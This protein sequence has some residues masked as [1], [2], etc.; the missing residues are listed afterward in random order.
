[1]LGRAR[2]YARVL[3]PAY[4]HLR[5]A[6]PISY[7]YYML[8][9]AI[10]VSREI[11]ALRT[12]AAGLA[13]CP[14]GASAVA[15]TDLPI[16]PARTAAL[17]GFSSTTRHAM[18]AVASRDVPLRLLGGAVGLAVVL[19]R[20]AADLQLWSTAEF[21]FIEFPDR[22]VGGSSA[23]PQKRNAFLLEHI[24]AKP[25]HAVGAWTAA[26]AMMTAAPFSNSIE[27][28]T[29]AM[30]AIWPGLH[31]ARQSV[32]LSQVIVG[33]AKPV[34]DRML[35]R[36]EQGFIVAT[37][38]ANRLVR[39]GVPFRAAHYLVGN[40]VR[41]AIEV[42]SVK[43]ADFGP[44]GW[45]D[46]IDESGLDLPVLLAAHVYGGGPGAFEPAFREAVAAWGAHWRWLNY[47]RRATAAAD[48]A[49]ED[50]EIAM[51]PS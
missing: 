33:G 51:G 40:A 10:A 6:M 26:V 23:M 12:A 34:P 15:G 22:L 2:T 11:D 18:D 43:L 3:M 45:L 36:A 49:L 7:G 47:A 9:I 28:G 35:E 46:G 37:A 44:P 19:S 27:V 25:G 1:M 38:L 29:E 20:L 16:D 42:G 24:K 13:E 17:L 30:A 31:A 8:G 39:T 14:L 50:A 32:L 5:A 41:S 4:T 48:A 21:G